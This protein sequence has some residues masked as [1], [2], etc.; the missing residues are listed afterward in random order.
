[1]KRGSILLVAASVAGLLVAAPAP[2]EKLPKV[3]PLRHKS[4]VEGIP[5]TE[6]RF[7]MVAVPGGTFRRGSP[8]GEAGRDADEGPPHVV[9]LGPLWVG[10]CEVTWDEFDAF[11]KEEIT[12]KK[13]PDRTAAE[14]EADAI[15]RPTPSYIDETRG[16]GHEGYPVIGVTHHAAMEYCRWLSAKTGR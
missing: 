4:Y 7:E 16:F 1:M 2:P 6:V 12:S 13:K 11:A 5:G 14:K 8:D 15:T 3:D 9:Q 10:R